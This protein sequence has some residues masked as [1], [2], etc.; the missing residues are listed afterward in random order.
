MDGYVGTAAQVA[1]Q[2]KCVASHAWI[3]ETPGAVQY[4]RVMGA[5]DPDSYGWGR[6]EA[7]L[8]EDGFFG[9]R[10][11]R[12][13]AVPLL[14]GRLAQRGAEIDCWDIFAAP[15]AVLCDRPLPPLADGLVLVE[16]AEA[17]APAP[18]TAIQSCMMGQGVV[19]LPGPILS[20]A[21]GPAALAAVG[22]PGGRVLSTAFAY[23]PHNAR[24]PYRD[25]AWSGL[26]ATVPE[27]RGQGLAVAAHIAVLRAIVGEHG[28]ARVYAQARSE[29]TASVRMLEK[30]G[31]THMPDRVSCIARMGTARFTR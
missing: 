31:M 3:M 11:I 2:R 20:G 10:L 28:A 29:N 23:F 19:P 13:N 4:G 9:F 22:A 17:A 1:L 16:G 7:A 6:I 5:D 12:R 14:R 8:D 21:L 15:A 26:V 24:S 25:W 27:A 18:L 30:S